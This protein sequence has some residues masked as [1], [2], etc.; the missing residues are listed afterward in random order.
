MLNIITHAARLFLRQLP[1]LLQSAGVICTQYALSSIAAPGLRQSQSAAR[2]SCSY[3]AQAR[4]LALPS[5]F[6]LSSTIISPGHSVAE[7]CATLTLLATTIYNTKLC[8]RLLL[9]QTTGL[10]AA[11]YLGLRHQLHLSTLTVIDQTR[12]RCN[13][14]ERRRR[15]LNPNYT[16][17]LQEMAVS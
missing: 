1:V 17:R 6:Q 15:R 4:L 7:T 14:K 10:A 5:L 11:A 8:N 12:V 2:E 9:L 13:C 16:S 3:I